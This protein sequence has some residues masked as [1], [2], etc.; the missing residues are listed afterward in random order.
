MKTY[1]LMVIFNPEVDPADDKKRDTLLA[2]MLQDSGVKIKSVNTIGKKQLSYDIRKQKEGV[3]VQATVEAQ[4][5][6]VGQIKKQSNLMP[7]ILRFLFTN[8][9]E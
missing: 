4:A 5:L 6:N 3:Y 9:K 7:E 8:I 2:K 1:E